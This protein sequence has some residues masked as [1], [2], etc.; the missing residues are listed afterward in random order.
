VLPGFALAAIACTPGLGESTASEV[1]SSS[2]S[3]SIATTGSSDARCGDGIADDGLFCFD[4][5][6]IVVDGVVTDLTATRHDGLSDVRLLVQYADVLQSQ[7]VVV[8]FTE[9]APV[10]SGPFATGVSPVLVGYFHEPTVQEIAYLDS[11][12][13]VEVSFFHLV[14]QQ[15][16][17]S[18]VEPVIGG[19][20]GRGAPIDVDGDG[21]LELYLLGGQD[22]QR[23]ARIFSYDA[24]VWVSNAIEYPFNGGT[25]DGAPAVAADFN[26]SGAPQL[27]AVLTGDSADS[28]YDPAL[29]RLLVYRADVTPMQELGSYPAGVIPADLAAGDLNGDT[30]PDLLVTG[31]DGGVAAL[32]C[33]SDGSFASP[34]TVIKGDG[35]RRVTALGDF[36]G[37]GALELCAA[38]DKLS[39]VNAPFGV[40]EEFVLDAEGGY[41]HVAASDFNND[42]VDDIA[43]ATATSLVVYISTP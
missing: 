14:E 39:I 6:P 23:W 20:S 31:V 18:V 9:A 37:D 26:G 11:Q 41:V 1:D 32:A 42:G 10:L 19:A 36:N 30:T 7:Q 24:G 5:V 12:D 35:T 28:V 27:A 21:R 34:V 17:E 25:I 38:G 13:G 16:T 43:A 29:H 33:A 40:L 15:V 22:G 3:A 8:T 2:S 4:A